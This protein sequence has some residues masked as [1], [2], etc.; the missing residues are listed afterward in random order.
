MKNFKNNI[1]K[2]L[3]VMSVLFVLSSCKKDQDNVNEGSGKMGTFT[4]QSKSMDIK[5]ADY[6]S[7]NGDG[8]WIYLMTKDFNTLQ[9]R[10]SGLAD[11]VIP[12]GSF[13][14]KATMPYDPAKNFRGGQVI[15]DN[16]GDEMTSGT[17]VVKKSGDK[18]TITV[19]ATTAKG[20]LTGDFEGAIEKLQ[21]TP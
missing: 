12:I 14:L 2:M 9:I 11:Y 20:P 7:G 21:I 16:V 19:N 17:V 13:T 8:A 5:T 18:Y 1:A 10:F 4:Y 3:M 6:R 15:V